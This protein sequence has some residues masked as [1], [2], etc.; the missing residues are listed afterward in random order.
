VTWSDGD[1]DH[2]ARK[3]MISDYEVNQDGGWEE[4]KFK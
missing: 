2:L 4:L 1:G 3:M